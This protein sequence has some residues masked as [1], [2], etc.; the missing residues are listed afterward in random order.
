MSSRTPLRIVLAGG[1]RTGKT[2]L[3]N[4]LGLPVRH[5]DDLIELGWVAAGAAA[6]KWFDAPGPWIV[7]G[8]TAPRAL[9]RWLKRHRR[10]KPCDVIVFL[11][12]PAIARTPGQEAMAKGCAKIYGEIRAAL[13]R[14]G[15]VE[16]DARALAKKLSGRRTRSARRRRARSAP[17]ATGRSRNRS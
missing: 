13:R 16:L 3:A 12:E 10:G 14:R 4:A 9:R 8:V 7:E 6:A 15:V 5:T 11:A 2:T 1:P 17:A